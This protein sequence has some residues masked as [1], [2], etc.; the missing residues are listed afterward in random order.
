MG[1]AQVALLGRLEVT[2]DGRTVAVQPGTED[3]ARAPERNVA[4][5]ALR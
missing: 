3:L 2:V 4:L 5:A 1:G